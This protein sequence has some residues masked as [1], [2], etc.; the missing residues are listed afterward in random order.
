MFEGMSVGS[1]LWVLGIAAAT[2]AGWGMFWIERRRSQR[3]IADAEAEAWLMRTVLNAIP[4]PILVKD[5]NF[6]LL[7]VNQ[8]YAKRAGVPAEAL[9]GKVTHEFMPPEQADRLV[10]A[11]VAVLESGQDQIYELTLSDRASNMLRDYIM[12]KRFARTLEGDPAIVGIHYDVTKL[13]RT[14][15]EFAAVI[16]QTPLVAVQGFD[17]NCVLTHW[18]RASEVLFGYSAEQAVGSRLQDII[19]EPRQQQVFERVVEEAWVYQ[20]TF[21]PREVPLRLPDGRRLVLLLTL[22]PVIVEGRVLELF[23]MAVDVTARHEAERQ[24]ALHRDNLQVLVAERTAGLLRVKQ[25]LEQALQA[26][27]EFLANMSHELRTPMHAVL[28][29]ARLG[30]TRVESSS[31]DKL[32][33]YFSRI[34][35]SGE[36]LLALINN[37][38][39]LSKF[40]AGKMLLNLREVDLALLLHDVADELEPLLVRQALALVLPPRDAVCLLE[41]DEA[42]IRQVIANLL[43]NAIRVSPTGGTI[44]I[45]LTSASMRL[46]RRATDSEACPAIALSIADQGPGIPPDELEAIF[47]KFTQS[48]VTRTGAGGTGLGL[49]ICREIVQAHQ[50]SI[51]AHNHEERGAIFEVVLPCRLYDAGEA[52]L[53]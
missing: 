49:A 44:H 16:E 39:D 4:E 7:L 36:R 27:S 50:G 31:P 33:D 23:S 11:D 43:S 45:S 15:A 35:I 3:R 9:I 5:Q 2:M 53:C 20:R 22:F 21:G 47:D 13:R 12:T 19:L 26:R 17:R 40:E 41:L 52:S 38:L 24:L 30:E 1:L 34:A 6:R 18:N 48:S 51:S 46:G 8:A 28:S 32:R 42:R 10:A 29:F 14:I 37:L 25:D